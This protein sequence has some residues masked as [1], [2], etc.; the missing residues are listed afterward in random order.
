MRSLWDGGGG[1]ELTKGCDGE[2]KAWYGLAGDMELLKRPLA[3]NPASRSCLV[4]CNTSKTKLRKKVILSRSSRLMQIRGPQ[5][6]PTTVNTATSG[7]SELAFCSSRFSESQS[8]H[9]RTLASPSSDVMSVSGLSLGE[10]FEE[11]ITGGC[12]RVTLQRLD[13]KSN[14]TKGWTVSV[15]VLKTVVET[16]G[17]E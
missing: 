1:G 6:A 8:F 9:P 3:V 16:A 11:S 7:K 14:F 12:E 10:T 5:T 15:F 17:S 13:S 4:I 2:Q